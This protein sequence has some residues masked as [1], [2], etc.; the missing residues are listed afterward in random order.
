MMMPPTAL[1]VALE[2]LPAVELLAPC[3][4][5]SDAVTSELMADAAAFDAVALEVCR[6]V[7]AVD[8]PA[9]RLVSSLLNAELR[10]VSTLVAGVEDPSRL[11]SNSLL[12]DC[13][14]R[15]LKAETVDATELAVVCV[16]ALVVTL[17]DTWVGALVLAARVD[18]E[19]EVAALYS[20]VKLAACDGEETELIDITC[21]NR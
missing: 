10:L 5:C 19:A 2:L 11:P 18:V 16:G 13:S 4:F 21:P 20:A 12:A 14:T 15:V 3:R 7:A 1:V 17:A 9:A 6:V 8:F